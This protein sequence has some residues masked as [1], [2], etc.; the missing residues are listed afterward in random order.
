MSEQPW[1]N[2]PDRLLWKDPDTGLWCF[3]RRHESLMHLCGY[4]VLDPEHPWNEIEPYKHPV[5][6]HGGPTFFGPLDETEI[7]ANWIGF[8]CAHA[9]DFSPGMSKFWPDDEYRTIDYV[10]GECSLLAKQIQEAR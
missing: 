7:S 9:G 1:L 3:I 6:V 4:V 5:E 2:E 8:D 10:K